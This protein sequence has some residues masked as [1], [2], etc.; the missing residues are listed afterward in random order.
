MKKIITLMLALSL[1]LS[2]LTA[3]S[4]GGG[5]STPGNIPSNS[6]SSSGSTP[7]NI[8]RN[9]G[10]SSDSNTSAQKDDDFI[11]SSQ[12]IPLEDAKRIVHES[13]EIYIDR[14]TGEP[15]LDK[16]DISLPGSTTTYGGDVFLTLVVTVN[17]NESYIAGV[18]R[19]I[20]AKLL[21]FEE[22][23]GVGEWAVFIESVGKTLCIGYKDI[24]L[25]IS[26]A[27]LKSVSIAEEDIDGIFMELGRLACVN[28][29]ALK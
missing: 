10:S 5:G 21:V 24:L 15:Q 14:K 17:Y 18:K 19:D 29:D 11:K 22:V 20:D 9:S 2:L 1:T 3:C 25:N 27:G 26:L 6:G 28:Y 8:P 16:P 12:L 7:D 23:D 4:G 13:L